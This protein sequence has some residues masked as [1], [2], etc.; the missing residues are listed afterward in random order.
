MPSRIAESILTHR[1]REEKHR[2]SRK[3]GAFW[4]RNRDQLALPFLAIETDGSTF[5]QIIE[6][7]LESLIL[8]AERLKMELSNK[9]LR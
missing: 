2:F 4:S 6:A 5:P 3:N 1:R 8:S 7:K 9:G